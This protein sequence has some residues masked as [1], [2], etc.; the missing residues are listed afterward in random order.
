MK[1]HLLFFF[2]TF[3]VI[4]NAIYWPLTTCQRKPSL[5]AIGNETSR[6]LEREADLVEFFCLS[7]YAPAPGRA[8]IP[9][10]WEKALDSKIRLHN[11]AGEI[12][13]EA[14]ELQ[15]RADEIRNLAPGKTLL[16]ITRSRPLQYLVV[17]RPVAIPNQLLFIAKSAES[18]RDLTGNP[19]RTKSVV[20]V[21]IV[22]I[23]AALLI[24]ILR[25]A[26]PK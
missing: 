18:T 6:M 13:S 17:R 11:G 20:P 15:M 3:L 8:A 26:F 5:N 19:T 22:S 9:A 21:I 1:K 2:V 24:T 10:E 16:H 25:A 14:A 4:A 7:R 23:A 12:V